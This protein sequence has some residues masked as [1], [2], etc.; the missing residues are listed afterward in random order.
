M[1]VEATPNRVAADILPD[2]MEAVV[3]ERI[4]GASTARVQ[5]WAK[6]DQGFSTETYLF[7]VAG[8]AG[9]DEPLGLVFRRPPENQLIPDYDLSSQ[10]RIMECLAD[11]EVPVPTVQWIESGPNVFG[12]QY[13]VMDRI[14]DVT[15]VSDVPPY[16][17]H[18]WF[19]ES[20]DAQRRQLW[21]GCVDMMVKVHA[22][23]AVAVGM[24][25]LDLGK[26]GSAPPQRLANYLRWAIEWTVGQGQIGGAYAHA[27]DWLDDNLYEPEKVCLCW[28]DAR[29]SNVLYSSDYQPVA[30]LDWEMSYLGDPAGDLAWMLTTDW[31][32]SPF[33]EHAPAP[34]V[35]SREETLDRYRTKTGLSLDHMKFSDITA[36]LLLA[37]PLMRLTKI[38][39]LG[40]DLA[41]VCAGRL[42]FIFSDQYREG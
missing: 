29:M 7:E 4:P 25:F 13:F 2:V 34:G 14:D 42:D 10:Y 24:G 35:P 6:A 22:V 3:R 33:P 26:F 21:D 1:T 28:G 15:T 30:A 9:R 39:D 40:A 17:Q 5:N 8:I 37:Q 23:D 31:L 36:T 18:G 20:S 41:E 11:S 32:S 19:A 16:H 12:S 38:Y 27:L